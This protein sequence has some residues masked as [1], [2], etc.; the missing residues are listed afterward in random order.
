MS[1]FVEWSNKY[2]IGVSFIDNQH[3]KLLEFTNTLYEGCKSGKVEAEDAFKAT[4]KSAVEYVKEHFSTEE[5]YMQKYGY[6]DYIIHKAEHNKF[7]KR[8]LEDVKAYMENRPFVPNSFVRFLKD[9]LL[10]HIAITDKKLGEFLVRKS[11]S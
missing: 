8:I 11:A 6:P 2:S 4:I 5:G 7:T 10:S 3:K 1:T 9:W